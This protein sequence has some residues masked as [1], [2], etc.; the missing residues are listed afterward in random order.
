MTPVDSVGFGLAFVAGLLSFLSPCVLPLIPS[1]VSFLTGLSLD[2]MGQR[3]W[4]AV[5]HALMFVA[6]FTIVFVALGA[7]ATALGQFM[8]G[9]QVWIER[10]G[11]V[12]I[13]FLGLYLMGAFQ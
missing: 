9:Q 5:S 8:R 6:G 10:F 2:Q 13:V 4:L 7:T 12:L 11:G 3:R 1:Y